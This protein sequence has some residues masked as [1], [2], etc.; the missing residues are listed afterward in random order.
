M[1]RVA[2]L[3]AA[4]RSGPVAIDCGAVIVKQRALLLVRLPQSRSFTLPGGQPL[5]GEDHQHCLQRLIEPTLGVQTGRCRPFGLFYSGAP[6][7]RE[8]H[9]YHLGIIGIPDVSAGIAEIAWV[10]H[11]HPPCHV[12]VSALLRDCV[13]ALLYQQELI[14]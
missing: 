1:H 3:P 14:N 8:H 4:I 10:T 11:R 5:R 6:G 2:L 13:M 12:S 9:I 7:M